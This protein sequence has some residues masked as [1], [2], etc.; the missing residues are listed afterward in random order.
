MFESQNDNS[1]DQQGGGN[2]FDRKQV[3]RNHILKQEPEQSCGDERYDDGL[4]EVE[5]ATFS[6]A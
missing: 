3:S 5:R 6:A 1:A 4:S 2:D